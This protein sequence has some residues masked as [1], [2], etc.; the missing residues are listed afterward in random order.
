HVAP[1]AVQRGRADLVTTR[2]VHQRYANA[3]RLVVL[4]HHARYERAH[5]QRTSNAVRRDGILALEGQYTVARHHG[6]LR[7]LPDL[8]DER[9]RDSVGE[10]LKLSAL[11][12]I[13]EEEHRNAIRVGAGA[14]TALHLLCVAHLPARPAECA[15]Y[16]DGEQRENGVASCTAAIALFSRAI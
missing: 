3:K 10:E 16:R 13:A 11:G 8:R 2:R 14:D 9:F 15:E 5:F 4:L 12:A 1:L 6:E 7:N